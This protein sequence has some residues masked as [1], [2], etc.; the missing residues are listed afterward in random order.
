[1][2]N[3]MDRFVFGLIFLILQGL[4]ISAT[5]LARD[6]TLDLTPVE[7]RWLDDHPTISLAY[8]GYFPPYSFLNDDGELEGFSIDLMA[9]ISQKTGLEFQVHPEH[10]WKAIY[11]SAQQQQ[12]DMVTSMVPRDERDQWFEFT[13]PYIFKSLVV[14]TQD[15]NNSIKQ[16]EDI[17]GKTIALVKDYQYGLQVLNEFPSITPLYVDTMLDALNA[18]SVGKADATISFLGAGHYYRT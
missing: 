1:M 13:K 15:E 2:W 7:Q 18:V 14:I 8:D 6:S 5:A 16:R 17:A 4:V 11:T 9:L 3:M 10:E 12:V